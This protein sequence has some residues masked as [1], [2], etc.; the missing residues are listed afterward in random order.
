MFIFQSAACFDIIPASVCKMDGTIKNGHFSIVQQH[1]HL[2][3]SL[4]SPPS[5]LSGGGGIFHLQFRLAP[6]G[7]NS[8]LIWPLRMKLSKVTKRV[9]KRWWCHR[10]QPGQQ[11]RAGLARRGWLNKVVIAHGGQ[12]KKSNFPTE[13]NYCPL[14]L[15]TCANQTILQNELGS[16]DG[17]FPVGKIIPE[18]INVCCPNFPSQG[19]STLLLALFWIKYPVALLCQ[20]EIFNLAIEL[21]DARPRLLFIECFTFK[22]ELSNWISFWKVGCCWIL[23]TKGKKANFVFQKRS[24]STTGSRQFVS[25]S[26]NFFINKKCFYFGPSFDQARSCNN[27]DA[28]KRA[29]EAYSKIFWA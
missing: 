25:E 13:I 1:F 8:R 9:G 14:K 21:P 22:V 28:V 7:G 2:L 17:W 26:P 15:A 11:I 3:A 12:L 19:L 16:K 10:S 23:C 24:T 5:P 20:K 29:T 18:N 6:K 4:L 27:A